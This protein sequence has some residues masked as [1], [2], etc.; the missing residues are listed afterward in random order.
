MVTT[1]RLELG[2]L[3]P[4]EVRV[5]PRAVVV[6]GMRQRLV[7]AALSLNA[8]RCVD[9]ADLVAAVWDE[10]PPATARQQISNAVWRLRRV[11]ARHGAAEV[12]R[13]QDNGYLLCSDADGVDVLRFERLV[14]QGR[15]L[16][17]AGETARSADV[18]REAL[19]LWRG[20]ALAGL[21]DNAVLRRH[22]VKLD[23]MR[24]SVLEECVEHE[25]ACGCHDRLVEQLPALVAEHPLRERLAAALMLALYRMGRQ[26]EA[27]AVYRRV[28]A[29]LAEELGVDPGP[30][31]QA[32]FRAILRADPALA[33]TAPPGPPQAAPTP[34][35]AVTRPAQLPAAAAVFVGRDAQLARLDELLAES[36]QAS[37]AVVITAVSGTAGVG[38]TAL[39]VQWA[40]RVAERFPDGQLY[41]NLRGFDPTGTVVA[42]ADAVRGFLDAL[43]VP[44]QRIPAD[45][46][47]QVALYRSLLAGRRILVVLDNARDADQ[48][49]PLLPGTPTTLVVVTSRNQ[50][51][52][53]VA[54]G[55]HPLTLHV[56]P[57]AAAR[58]MLTRR[59]GPGRVDAE[60]EAVSRIVAACAGLPLAL[61]ITAA[62]AQQTAFPLATIAAELADAR[63]R[64]AALDAGDAVHQVRA[65]FSWSY[66][67]LAAPAARLFRLLGL[68]PAPDVSVA[69]AASLAGL[70]RDEAHRLLT[71]LTR[72]SLLTEPNPGRY[73]F[74]DLLRAYATERAQTEENADERHAVLTRL[75]DHYLHAAYSGAVVLQHPH[76]APMTPAPA[77]AGVCVETLSD[78]RRAMV[79]FTTEQYVLLAA[80]QHAA[81][82]G[83]RTHT[84][85]LAWSL[86]TFLLPQGRWTDW[87][88]VQQAALDAARDNHDELGQAIAH[89]G[90]GNASMRLGRFVDA[91]RHLARALELFG[92]LGDRNSQARTH[93]PLATLF[94][95]QAR[96]TEALDHAQRSLE[97]HRITGDRG[98]QADA[99][100]GVG[101]YHSQLGNYEQA[102]LYCSEAI[103]LAQELGGQGDEGGAWDSLGYAHHHLG[104]HAEAIRCYRIAL[105]RYRKVGHR[106]EEADGLTRLGEI[107]HAV[108]DPAAARDTWQQALDIL[109]DIDHPDTSALRTKLDNLDLLATR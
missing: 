27:V 14:A 63:R 15:R 47:A 101:W 40:H 96:Y 66:A 3:G 35:Q 48:V 108:G 21:T 26:A 58:Q 84:W 87:H 79:W 31:L 28:A 103:A 71:D 104:R 43:G 99:L 75:L 49:R 6:G 38:K 16:A 86:S 98:G 64:L 107:Y 29:T 100:N 17:A 67:A 50:L 83:F 23:E 88:A 95:K 69:A 5:G 24:L 44:P 37:T 78:H 4:L 8:G 91:H 97:L 106:Y 33:T 80:I 12:V 9:L 90:L 57:P 22:A 32:R 89:R 68:H 77:A 30:E 1:S 62:R 25:L 65:V 55:A 52:G 39:A 19:A 10:E 85:Q 94:G 92:E 46:D 41:V 93:L 7:L 61:A 109:T 76:P 45:P 59:L 34:G 72:A 73:T 74:H 60:P 102:V 42:S 51:T 82:R 53:L 2:V 56:L 81:A 18:L 13:R 36:A 70:P 20:P 11:L 54:D 105:D